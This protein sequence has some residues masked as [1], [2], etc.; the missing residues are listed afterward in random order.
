[1]KVK[2]KNVEIQESITGKKITFPKY[3][4]QLMNLANSNSQATRPRNVGQLS[5]L[6]QEFGGNNI[7][8]WEIFYKNKFPNAINIASIKIYE[9]C[10]NFGSNPL[11]TNELVKIWVEDLIISKTFIGLKFQ[12]AILS[13]IA[14]LKKS[15]YR[16]ATKNEESQN[17]DGVIGDIF[18][19]IKPISYKSKIL[20]EDISIPIIF[21][22]K[23]KDGISIEFD[24]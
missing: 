19:S 9:M 11:I 4:T 3:T 17:I 18:V 24:F 16:L 12:E 15:A 21:Y 22:S 13:K 7:E 20:S 1:M 8:D 10:L 23:K 5:D 14:K 6:I 2:I